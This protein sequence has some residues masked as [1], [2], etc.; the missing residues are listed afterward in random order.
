MATDTD[1]VELRGLSPRSVIAYVDGY[2]MAKRSNRMAV[3][4]KILLAWARDQAHVANVL[5]NTTR[6]N[7]ALPDTGW[8]S[9]E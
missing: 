7:P 5:Q 1:L 3:I 6:G 9:L 8:D 2:A 4:N